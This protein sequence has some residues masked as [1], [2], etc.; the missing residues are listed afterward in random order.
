LSS[1]NRSLA[2]E[3]STVDPA[4]IS[5]AVVVADE[6]DAGVVVRITVV[7]GCC[8]FMN[9]YSAKAASKPPPINSTVLVVLPDTL[10]LFAIL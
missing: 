7:D 10:F 6:V 5:A 4:A 8:P 2:I 9:S 3:V 1:P